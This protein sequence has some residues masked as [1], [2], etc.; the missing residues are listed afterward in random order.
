MYTIFSLFILIIGLKYFILL[1]KYYYNIY[2]TKDTTVKI[3][4][5]H[6]SY[7]LYI[8]YFAYML[9]ANIILFI[10]NY[11]SI[12]SLSILSGELIFIILNII[13]VVFGI[14]YT[15]YK[16]ES[17]IDFNK[18]LRMSASHS[19]MIWFISI[20][21]LYLAFLIGIKF[22]LFSEYF[23]K[24]ENFGIFKKIYCEGSSGDGGNNYLNSK[25]KAPEEGKIT[26]SASDRTRYNF[27]NASNN[28]VAGDNSTISNNTINPLKDSTTTPHV[29]STISKKEVITTTVL[30]NL[31]NP[32][33]KTQTV[34]REELKER[35]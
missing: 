23:T 2:K 30:S 1:S 16:H 35:N 20:F 19:T 25:L 28:I 10:L 11:Y 12:L 34:S 5:V 21:F 7:Y 33:I 32:T 22:N 14:Y 18:T 24:W 26:P 27:T 6:S 9:F 29:K 3:D 8:L 15:I 17:K 31:K 4:G 13:S